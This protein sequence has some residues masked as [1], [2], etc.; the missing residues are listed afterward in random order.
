V[1][2]VFGFLLHGIFGSDEMHRSLKPSRS[3]RQPRLTHSACV[4]AGGLEG[5]ML[6]G[7]LAM[8]GNAPGILKPRI[9]RDPVPPANTVSQDTP[10]VRLDA[11]TREC[12]RCHAALDVPS[13]DA[14]CVARLCAAGLSLLDAALSPF[15]AL[16]AQQA[17]QVA[18]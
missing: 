18:S 8:K 2:A 3:A 17:T 10:A 16:A 5:P 6:R 15:G 4:A 13:P 9:F 14:A 1:V 7:G 11:H 12:A